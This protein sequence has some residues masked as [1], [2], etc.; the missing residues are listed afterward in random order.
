MQNANNDMNPILG[1]FLLTGWM[2]EMTDSLQ[3]CLSKAGMEGQR[4]LLRIRH[5]ITRL[6]H[7]LQMLQNGKATP[8]KTGPG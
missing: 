4:N 5:Q 3:G 6:E 8:P 2:R 1:A 7:D